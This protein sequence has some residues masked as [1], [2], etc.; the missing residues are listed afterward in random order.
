MLSV[1]GPKVPS[2]RTIECWCLQFKR[3]E[4]GLAAGPWLGR[5]VEVTVLANVVLVEKVRQEDR[6]I[7]YRQLEELLHIP[8]ATYHKIVTKH[9]KNF[10]HFGCPI[11]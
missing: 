10:V 6:R 3:C 2:L 8:V 9:V 1:F 4:L 11:H 5:P 7:T